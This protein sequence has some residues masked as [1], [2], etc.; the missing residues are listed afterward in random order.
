MLLCSPKELPCPADGSPHRVVGLTLSDQVQP[1][2]FRI[3]GR[4]V[5]E[6]ASM[7]EAG[8]PERIFRPCSNGHAS[9]MSRKYRNNSKSAL[10]NYCLPSEHFT[11]FL[12]NKSNMKKL[13]TIAVMIDPD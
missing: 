2:I 1:E 6:R 9:R 4:E 12:T 7:I 10:K 11:P 3:T 8:C 5:G 13:K